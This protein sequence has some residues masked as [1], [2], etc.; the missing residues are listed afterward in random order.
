MRYYME[1]ALAKYFKIFKKPVFLDLTVL[2][3]LSLI[4]RLLYLSTFVFSRSGLPQ[5]DDSVWY[6][7]AAKAFFHSGIKMHFNDV[8]YMGY[9]SFLAVLFAVLKGKT[10]IVLFQVMINAFSVIFVY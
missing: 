10:L 7:N 2:V 1:M 3:I 9:V 4:P 6:I 5:T 8:L